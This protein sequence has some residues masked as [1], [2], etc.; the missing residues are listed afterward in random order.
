MIVKNGRVVNTYYREGYDETRVFVL[1]S[2]SK[3]VTSALVG[4]AIQRGD[5]G[6]ADDLLADYLPR[7]RELSD[8]RW[9]EITL[10]Q[11]LTHISGLA[12]TDSERW[13]AWRS[14]E[15]W[16]EYIFALPFAGEPGSGF[17]YSTGNTHLLSA[18][19]QSATG[20]T[21]SDFAQ[22]V[23]FDPMELESARVDADPQG[24]GDGGN[25]IWMTTADMAKFGLLYLNGGQWQEQ[26]LVPAAWVEQST[27]AQYERG[28][29]RA[30]YGF[31]WWV[32]T[33]GDE[34]YPAYFAQGHGG[35]YILVVPQLALVVAWN[36]DYEGAT[37]I[38]WQ[39]AD[40][41]VN[42]CFTDAV[43][44]QYFEHLTK[45]GE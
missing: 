33:F 20:V 7:V 10:R 2:A 23:L 29:G 25:G 1:N 32:R 45:T 44:S 18:V 36:S 41:I 43:D 12:S 3:S 31:Q 5:I 14:S 37:S 8:P 11:L 34:K 15:N 21:L 17:S 30:A 16:L 13:T 27:S 6:S 22:A 42:A 40:A 4:I 9:Q 24:I 35:Q 38:Y 39:M 28:G 19:L 26:Q